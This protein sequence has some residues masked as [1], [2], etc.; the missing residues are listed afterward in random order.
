MDTAPKNMTTYD[1][2]VEFVMI[3]ALIFKT[4]LMIER[5]YKSSNISFAFTDISRFGEGLCSILSG[6][7]GSG[8]KGSGFDLTNGTK[9]NEVKTVCFCQPHKCK[10]CGSSVPWTSNTCANCNSTEL[11]TIT[12]S[13]FG[14]SAKAHVK[15]KDELETYWLVLIEHDSEDIFKITVWTLKSDNKYFTNYINQQNKFASTTCNLLPYSYDFYMSNP[16]QRLQIHIR[17]P[18]SHMDDPSIVNMEYKDTEIEMPCSILTRPELSK[19]GLNASDTISISEANDILTCRPK[20]HG[21]KRGDTK[22]IL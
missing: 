2:I 15:Y 13:R 14:I 19:L 16:I 21:K 11:K 6:F 5:K 18:E 20:T 4:S 9:A 10:K 1:E 22:R 8:G 17:L 7:K 12:D 3:Y